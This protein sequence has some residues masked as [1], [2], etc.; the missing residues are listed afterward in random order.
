[1]KTVQAA[2]GYAADE[3]GNGVAYVRAQLHS[4]APMMLR[5]L[6]KVRRQPALLG[7]EIG[8]AALNA[9]VQSLRR[10]G[11]ERVALTIE[12][13]RLIDELQ[14]RESVPSALTLPYVRLGCALNQFREYELAPLGAADADLPVRARSEIDAH[15]AA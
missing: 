8:Y 12:D 10:R 11:F 7:R 13:A 15:I 4:R 9:V 2:A 14:K 1:M 3:A 6:F 5:V